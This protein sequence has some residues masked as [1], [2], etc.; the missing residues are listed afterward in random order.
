[1]QTL[2][3]WGAFKLLGGQLGCAFQKCPQKAAQCNAVHGLKPNPA[4]LSVGVF[5]EP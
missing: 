4:G 1:M 3:A 2:A 5:S